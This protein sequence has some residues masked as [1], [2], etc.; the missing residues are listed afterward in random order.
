MYKCQTK[1]AKIIHWK[2]T[3]ETQK[4]QAEVATTLL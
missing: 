3:R 1:V 4:I 2:Y